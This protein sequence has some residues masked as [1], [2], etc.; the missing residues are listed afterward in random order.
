VVQAGTQRLGEA[1]WPTLLEP[2]KRSPA[3]FL[4]AGREL[5]PLSGLSAVCRS[6]ATASPPVRADFYRAQR[7]KAA[8]VE[9]Q[10]DGERSSERSGEP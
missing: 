8:Q 7:V 2:P 6:A 10:G 5:S 3:S 1:R 9:G 4:S